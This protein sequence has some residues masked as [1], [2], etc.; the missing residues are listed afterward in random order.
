[1]KK[2]FKLTDKERAILEAIGEMGEK[3][4]KEEIMDRAN[5]ILEKIRKK[6]QH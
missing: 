1:M 6:K 2:P 4:T 3:A 5:E